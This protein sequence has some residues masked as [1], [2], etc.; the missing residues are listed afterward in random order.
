MRFTKMQA[1]GND[2]VLLDGIKEDL[3]KIS[4]LSSLAVK[5]C[6]RHFGI[7]ADGLIL[8]QPSKAANFAMRIFNADGSEAE[9]CGNGIRC[10][11]KYVYEAKHTDKDTISVETKAGVKVVVLLIKGGRVG[12][13]EV[14]MG[15]PAK[16]RSSKFEVSAA[17]ARLPDGQG[18]AFGGQGFKYEFT[19][20][21][22]GNPHAVIFVN[23]LS[24][25]DLAQIGPSIENHENFPDRTNVEF[26]QVINK[27]ELK[28]LV[29]ERG[30]GETLACGTGAC[31]SLVA[32][33][34]KGLTGR[35]AV[36]N[37]PGGS[38]IVEWDE[39]DHVCLTGPAEEV[40]RGEISA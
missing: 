3:S 28:V 38:L 37:L 25:I 9:M 21:S 10:F 19:E 8:V 30:V 13:V 22:M 40:F 5:V 1:T 20:V 39:D 12:A 18:S 27:K 4:D 7:G 35:D 33:A 6:D 24:E 34:T 14:D 16:V 11:A 32:A 31:A 23:D 26:V 36:V 2:F 29:W 17:G 15:T